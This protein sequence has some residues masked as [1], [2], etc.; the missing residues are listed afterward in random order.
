MTA[1]QILD[2]APGYKTIAGLVVL[3]LGYFG[4]QIEIGAVLDAITGIATAI[5]SILTAY[6]LVMKIVRRLRA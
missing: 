3:V 5:G 4:H 6:G 1:M 2:F